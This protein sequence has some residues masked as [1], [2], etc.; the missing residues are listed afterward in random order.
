M[1]RLTL[2]KR[3]TILEDKRASGS[4]EDTEPEHKGEGQNEGICIQ[5]QNI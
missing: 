2:R 1:K 5:L 4:M 3:K